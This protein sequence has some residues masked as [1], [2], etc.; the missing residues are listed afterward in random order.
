[1]RTLIVFLAICS[2]ARAF[3]APEEIPKGSDL[4]A[5]LFDL[6]R[7]AVVEEV[8]KPVKFLGSLKQMDGWA[9]FFGGLVDA[10]GKK[11]LLGGT[12]S[13]DSVIL[14]KRTGG[15]WRVVQCVVGITDVCYEAWPQKYGVP[16]E[17][18]F[19]EG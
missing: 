12:E 16:R 10:N 7:P 13:S 15:K 1:M 3:A 19:P 17:L 5:A 8:G 9:F 11:I 6:A 2:A 4:R 18:L 14:W